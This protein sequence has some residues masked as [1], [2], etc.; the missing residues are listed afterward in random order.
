VLDERCVE[1]EEEVDPDK[2]AIVILGG[3]EDIGDKVVMVDKPT[4]AK[5]IEDVEN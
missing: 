5:D 4:M 2:M 3:K 1:L